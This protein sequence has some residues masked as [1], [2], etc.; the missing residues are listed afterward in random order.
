[1]CALY[2]VGV[3]AHAQDALHDPLSPIHIADCGCARHPLLHNRGPFEGM[4]LIISAIIIHNQVNRR[5]IADRWVQFDLALLFFHYVSI[6]LQAY[7]M[8]V[9]LFPNWGFTYHAYY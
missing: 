8:M 1:M 7:E 6:M 3:P 5:T 2:G 4:T 9:G